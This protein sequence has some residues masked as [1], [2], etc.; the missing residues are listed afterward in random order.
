MWPVVRDILAVVKSGDRDIV[1]MVG[2]NHPT[3]LARECLEEDRHR[4]LDFIVL[5][6]GEESTNHLL[7]CITKGEGI[8]EVDGL[9]YRDG[10]GDVVIQEKTKQ[11]EDLDGIAFPAR[12]LMPIDAYERINIPHHVLS[13]VGKNTS[14][15]TSRGCP[16]RCTFCSSTV[17][18]AHGK[19][20]RTRSVENIIAE[21]EEAIDKFGITEFNI[22]D[23]NFTAHPKHVKELLREIIRRKLNIT[24][25]TP[26]GIAMWTLDEELLDLMAE[27]G[28][29]EI[30][31]PF[32]S[33]DQDTLK[34]LVKKPLRLKKAEEVIAHVKK[35]G[36][37]YRSF[38]IIGFPGQT[39][40]SIDETLSYIRKLGLDSADLF[41]AFPLPGAPMARECFEKG[42]VPADYDFTQNTSTRGVITTEEFTAEEITDIVR[43][44]SSF[45]D[46]S[47]VYRN[48]KRF[49]KNYAYLLRRPQIFKE[50]LYRSARRIG[51]KVIRG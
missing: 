49:I 43:T 28:L 12:D 5:G 3:F 42:Y 16:A 31:L 41:A 4:N 50:I 37:R 2:G 20:Y 45:H 7:R 21:I 11:I 51:R 9:A 48:P 8:E 22:E 23:D 13:R 38:W 10:A 30:V 44:F 29:Q 1:T 15:F 24:W 17:F 35:L 32:E 6:E 25:N 33:G 34:E 46:L 18:W 36:L 39:R 47:L 14:L 40:E 19:R 26:N 27:S